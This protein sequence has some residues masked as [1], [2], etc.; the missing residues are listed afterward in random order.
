[1]SGPPT[2]SYVVLEIA[3]GLEKS[4]VYIAC[5][6][7]KQRNC[8]GAP[9]LCTIPNELGLIACRA[10]SPLLFLNRDLG[11]GRQVP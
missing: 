2:C 5:K 6:A 10:Q 4:R 11:M 7:K 1:M 3:M 8:T 9:A